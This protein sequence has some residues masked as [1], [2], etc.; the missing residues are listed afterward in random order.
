MTA[1]EQSGKPMA[2]QVGCPNC[3]GE[4]WEFS[5]SV[6]NKTTCS[7]C[8][9]EKSVS[10]CAICNKVCSGVFL[11]DPAECPELEIG[12]TNLG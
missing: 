7:L 11:K 2:R 9:G 3:Q 8:N 1:Q 4:G 10:L 12:Q 5:D 6:G